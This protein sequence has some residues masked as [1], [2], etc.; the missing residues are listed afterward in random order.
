MDTGLVINQNRLVQSFSKYIFH[1]VQQSLYYL[2]CYSLVIYILES[3]YTD[4]FQNTCMF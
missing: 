4:I 2:H 3:L 1:N